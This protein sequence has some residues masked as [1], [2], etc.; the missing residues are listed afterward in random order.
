MRLITNI[1]PIL[2]LIIV[3]VIAL[4]FIECNQKQKNHKS[5]QENNLFV[6]G[7]T[8]LFN[9]ETL[10]SWKITQFGPQGP[11]NVSEGRIILGMGDGC[12]GVTWK[13]DFPRIN[14]EVS[15]EAMKITGNDFFCGITFP[16]HNDY[17]SLIVGGWG[18]TVV[19]LSTIDGVDASENNTSII[20]SFNKKEWYRIKLRV[21]E[22]EIEAWINDE[23]VVDF[24]YEGKKLSIRPEVELS[25]PFGITSWQTTAALRNI[26]LKEQSY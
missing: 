14:Y 4:F 2:T 15:L 5:A 16:I 21:T 19:G 13:K 20:R 24:T 26:Y 6:P 3:L 17:C 11:V 1:A 18:G 10:N 9:G 8:L 25:I 23:Q 22:K 12:T 7:S